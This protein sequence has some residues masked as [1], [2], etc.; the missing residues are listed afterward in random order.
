MQFRKLA[1]VAVVLLVALSG[2]SALG[3][4]QADNP[5]NGTETEKNKTGH[6]DSN[7]SGNKLDGSSDLG[8][9][10]NTVNNGNSTTNAEWS[11]PRKPNG[12]IERKDDGQDR[13]KNV[14]FV[15]KEPAVNGEGYSNFN[16]QVTAN[17]SMENVDPPNHGDVVGEPYFFIK[18]NEGKNQRKIIE[19][20]GEVSMKENGTFHI[21]VRPAGIEEFGERQKLTVE[22]YLM[23]KDSEWDDV[24]GAEGQNIHFNPDN[25]ANSSN[26]STDSTT[27]NSSNSSEDTTTTNSSNTTE[28]ETSSK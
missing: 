19:R 13:I 23:D 1:V 15:D 8:N 6:A 17:T 24:Y 16:V 26:S 4:S 21:D 25:S 2:C 12:P 20:T 10:N 5:S 18:I 3:G 27:T 14:K 11:P 22:V 9:N 28:S 7:S